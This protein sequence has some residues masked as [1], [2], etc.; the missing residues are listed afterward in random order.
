ME[1]RLVCVFDLNLILF[2]IVF[3]SVRV[4]CI[5]LEDLAKQQIDLEYQ[6]GSQ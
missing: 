5:I 6:L 3:L 2:V 4:I 1:S